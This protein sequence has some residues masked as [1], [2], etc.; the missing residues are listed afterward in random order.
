MKVLLLKDVYKLGH[1]GD[2]KKVADG[3]ARNYLIPQGMAALATAKAI[4]QAET[5][6][7]NAAIARAKLNTELSGAAERINALVVTFAAKAGET[8]KLYGS[9]TSR[10]ITDAIK[11]ASGLEVD[12][13]NV[14]HQPLREL[15]DFKVAVRLT[16]DL[17]PNVRVIVHREGEVWKAP[18]AEAPAPEAPVA[19]EPPAAVEATPA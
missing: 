15:G 18:V 2:V 3:Y 9:I 1:A 10:Q 8:G 5:L 19:V 7:Q 12:H 4:Q 17:I 13:R 14:G 16:A 11:A 6:R